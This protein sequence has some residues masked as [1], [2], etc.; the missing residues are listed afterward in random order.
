MWIQYQYIHQKVNQAYHLNQILEVEA[1]NEQILLQKGTL[2]AI[3]YGFASAVIYSLAFTVH[4]KYLF[5][6]YTTSY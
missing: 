1:K 4:Q 3:K 2:Y 5:C 6:Y